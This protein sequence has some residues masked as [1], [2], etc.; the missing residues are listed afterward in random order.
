MDYSSRG[1]KVALALS[2]LVDLKSQERKVKRKSSISAPRL[3]L[4]LIPCASTVLGSSPG[5]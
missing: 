1:K 4:V 3:C 5:L 2:L